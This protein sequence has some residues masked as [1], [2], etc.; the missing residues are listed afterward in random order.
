MNELKKEASKEAKWIKGRMKAV[1]L[2]L[3][4]RKEAMPG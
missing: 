2:N 4:Q 3:R 1:L